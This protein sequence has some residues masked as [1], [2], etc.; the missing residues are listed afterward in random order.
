MG[1]T[2]GRAHADSDGH[3]T[4]SDGSDATGPEPDARATHQIN[5]SFR[6]LISEEPFATFHSVRFLAI[7]DPLS[8]VSDDSRLLPSPS[9][10]RL[11]RR[12]QTAW[13]IR[14]IRSTRLLSQ[15]REPN[16]NV[17]SF[18]NRLRLKASTMDAALLRQSVDACL[19]GAAI[20]WYTGRPRQIWGPQ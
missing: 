14:P 16:C 10:W 18:T 12:L 13:S 6:R 19:L 3:S 7:T 8:N 17:F 4:Q 15:V 20:D 2:D 1:P 5:C 11:T 9:S